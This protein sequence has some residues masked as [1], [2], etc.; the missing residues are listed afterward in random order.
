MSYRNSHGTI[1]PQSRFDPKLAASSLDKAIKDGDDGKKQIRGILTSINNQQR[2][3]VSD[4]ISS[5]QVV[6]SFC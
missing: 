2:Q 4:D 1:I 6:S 5:E 3:K